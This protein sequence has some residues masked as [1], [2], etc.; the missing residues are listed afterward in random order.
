MQLEGDLM[1]QGASPQTQRRGG[2]L[3]VMPAT[4][5]VDYSH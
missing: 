4:R 3:D 2:P 5:L 1:W